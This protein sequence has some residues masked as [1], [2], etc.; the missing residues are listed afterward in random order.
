MDIILFFAMYF[1]I[2]VHSTTFNKFSKAGMGTFV[3]FL[4][5]MHGYTSF[6]CCSLIMMLSGYLLKQKKLTAS[7]YSKLIVIVIEYLLCSLVDVIFRVKYLKQNLCNLSIIHGFF[8]FSN[9]PNLW[10]A[11]MYIGLFL[12]ALYL[13]VFYNNIK[14]I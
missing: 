10:Y 11:N 4:C 14:S 3:L 12:F 7:Y 1:V 13:N 9:A 5:G 6:T 8:T 2:F